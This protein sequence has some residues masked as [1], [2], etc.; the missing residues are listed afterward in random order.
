MQDSLLHG[1]PEAETFVTHLEC[2]LTGEHY[3]ADVPHNLSR[4]GRPL[5]VRYD[6]AAVRR[7]L[8]REVLAARAPTLWKW[9][10]LLPVRR[11]ADVVTLGETAH[12]D[13]RPPP[14]G[15]PLWGTGAVGEGRWRLPTGSFKARGLVMAVSMAKAF[16]IQAHG[17]A[18]Q[19]Q[20]RGGAGRLLARALASRPTCSAP[21]TRP[22]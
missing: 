8:T 22:R 21:R 2:S 14:A 18:K 16:G 15:R 12:A 7:R 6:L 13:L 20:C 4:A 19:R 5:L 9:R 17:D 1:V 10:E 11:T 3:P